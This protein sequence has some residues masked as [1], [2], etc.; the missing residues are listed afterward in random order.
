MPPNCCHAT[1]NS[2]STCLRPRS[3]SLESATYLTLW[4]RYSCWI[5]LI[6]DA[7]QFSEF[8]F[9]IDNNFIWLF[10]QKSF[11]NH[12]CRRGHLGVQRVN[13]PIIRRV[14]VGV[15]AVGIVGG[16]VINARVIV[17]G[18]TAVVTG[19]SSVISVASRLRCLQILFFLAVFQVFNILGRCL[20][21]IARN[22]SWAWSW[23]WNWNRAR[24]WCWDGWCDGNEA[25]EYKQ[26]CL[27][28]KKKFRFSH[29][30]LV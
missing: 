2:H 12:N 24:S 26:N 20:L 17:A 5:S 23:E 18:I 28:K 4:F 19:E 21:C 10:F 8:S 13:L 27:Q 30:T 7:K 9:K 29:S 22:W 3:Q 16:R 11:L 6:T 14:A 1:C 25:D 15:I